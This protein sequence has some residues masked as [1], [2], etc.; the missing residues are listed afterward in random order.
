MFWVHWF[1]RSNSTILCAKVLVCRQAK[2]A[3][4]MKNLNN[5]MMVLQK[6]RRKKS[7][8]NLFPHLLSPSIQTDFSLLCFFFFNRAQ[9]GNQR[10]NQS[11]RQSFALNY[12]RSE[13]ERLKLCTYIACM[14]K[15]RCTLDGGA[16]AMAGIQSIPSILRVKF[17][18]R[19]F[20]RLH[21][22]SCICFPSLDRYAYAVVIAIHFSFFRHLLLL[23]IV[24]VVV[25]VEKIS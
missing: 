4:K 2:A 11:R 19:S 22:S 25:R 8:G 13:E 17:F 1:L 23:L 6:K 16:Y 9:S 14:I 21:P 10:I 20:I 3:L 15:D 18:W 5:K 7:I 24:V 12:F